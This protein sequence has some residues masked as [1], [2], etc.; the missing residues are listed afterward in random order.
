MQG[1]AAWACPVQKLVIATNEND[2]LRRG[3]L[4]PV[5]T[6][7]LASGDRD[8]PAPSDGHPGFLEIFER[9]LF[10]AL[11][12]DSAALTGLMQGL[13]VNRAASP[14]PQLR[15]RP[16]G[17]ISLRQPP[18]RPKPARSSSGTTYDKSG[19]LL[20]PHTAV[21]VSVANRAL[22]GTVPMVTLATA[23]PAKFPAAVHRATGIEPAVPAGLADLYSRPERFDVLD[24]D[25]A[26]VEAF[27]A[28]RTRA[29]A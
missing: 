29:A 1:Q 6:R 3:A 19:Y 10:E 23:H 4:D 17:P 28:A 20:D 8:L 5:A 21:G 9:L 14:F 24:N 16:S 11:G 12:G 2:I 13:G 27:I 18:A 26:A 22:D 7:P 25:A 15:W